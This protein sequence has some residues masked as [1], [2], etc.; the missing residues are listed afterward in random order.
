MK[1]IIRQYGMD[2]MSMDVPEHLVG[3]QYINYTL[4]PDIDMQG[5]HDPAAEVP[6]TTVELSFVGYEER[7]RE[8][9][10]VYKVV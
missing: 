1:A 8:T 4:T 7:G 2:D 3:K 6:R 10:P 9:L 5:D